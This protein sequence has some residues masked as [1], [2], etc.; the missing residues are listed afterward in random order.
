[1]QTTTTVALG[2]QSDWLDMDDLHKAISLDNPGNN[3][4][5]QKLA[6]YNKVDS[7]S[8]A[9][10]NPVEQN[11]DTPRSYAVYLSRLDY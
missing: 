6:D 11:V 2:I 9:R 7:R 4:V 1:M 3:A 5:E 8:N 10:H